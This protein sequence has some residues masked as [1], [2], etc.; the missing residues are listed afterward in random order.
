MKK[1]P[2]NNRRGRPDIVHIFLLT[3]FDSILSSK[4]ELSVMVHTRNNELIDFK[5]DVRLPKNFNR[6]IG[7]MEQ[8][9][10]E[11]RVPA[12]L[13]GNTPEPLIELIPDKDLSSLVNK[14]R[15][16]ADDRGSPL[17]V[18]ILSDEGR[19]VSARDYFSEARNSGGDLL[20]ILGGFP[21]GGF[22]TD[23]TGLGTVDIISIH[24]EPLKT[25]T[26][27]AE[28]LVNYRP[29][30]VTAEEDSRDPGGGLP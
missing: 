21:E 13:S 8:L 9:F 30:D 17:S 2:D 22:S 27:A 1:L 24:P 4:G 26:V 15:K 11:G 7:L 28:V 10:T 3:A 6:F 18:V 25:W 23:L 19:Q 5:P 12:R 16:D 29:K 20:C 14:L